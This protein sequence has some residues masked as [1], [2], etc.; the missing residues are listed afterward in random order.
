MNETIDNF[1]SWDDSEV[2]QIGADGQLPDE[3]K[4]DLENKDKKKPITTQDV[5]PKPSPTPTP[6]PTSQLNENRHSSS[7]H[8][9]TS[10]NV[11]T[12]TSQPA[13]TKPVNGAFGEEVVEEVV[14]VAE[15]VYEEN[16]VIR[17]SPPK[18]KITDNYTRKVGPKMLAA[19]YSGYMVEFFNSG[20]ELTSDHSIFKQYGQV[21]MEKK[22]NGEIAYLLG[23]FSSSKE[24][25][26]YMEKI[27]TP[28]FP[29]AKVIQYENGK[30]LN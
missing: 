29:A 30:R 5:M 26:S 4:R 3:I 21:K 10:N 12:T 25:S 17:P 24:A 14:E 16:T 2:I 11:A 8:N 22:S 28:R 20:I 27:I 7:N 1:S 9:T 13:V 6:A 19:D 23:G 15:E 18:K